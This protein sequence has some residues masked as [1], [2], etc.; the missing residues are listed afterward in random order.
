MEVKSVLSKNSTV[1]IQDALDSTKFW[2]FDAVDSIF[3]LSAFFSVPESGF[4]EY[5]LD[6]EINADDLD[7][8]V[9]MLIS[10]LL[11]NHSKSKK[12]DGEEE[13][14]AGKK[15]EKEKDKKEGEKTD[16]EES[17]EKGEKTDKKESRESVIDK[18]RKAAEDTV[19]EMYDVES[20]FAADITINDVDGKQWKIP[21]TEN[22]QRIFEKLAE[23]CGE[24]GIEEIQPEHMLAACFEVNDEV[25]ESFFEELAISFSAAKRHFTNKAI[26][27]NGII[28]YMYASFLVN[29]NTDVDATK[30]CPI[31]M[32]D[33]E[34]KQLWNI[35]HKFNKRNAV[36]V[37]EA[38]VGKTALIELMAYQ[39]VTE[40]CPEKFK[41]FNM[42]KLD[43]NSLI[44]GTKYRGDAEER[45]EGLIEFLEERNNVI[46]FIDEVHTIL[47]AGS[48]FEGEM[49]L[50]NA[51]KPILARGDTIVIGATTK[52]EYEKYFAKDAALARRF[53]VITVDEPLAEDVYPMIKNKIEI[54]SSFHGVKI[55]RE[56]VKYAILIASCFENNKKNPDRTLDLIDRSMV[57]AY[58]AGK[59]KVDKACVLENFDAFFDLFK[60]MTL[61]S[62]KEIAYHEIGHLLVILDSETLV[63]HHFLAISIMPT[64]EYFGVTVCENEKKKMPFYNLEYFKDLLAL[65]LA[66]RISEREFHGDYTSGAW[67]DL[68]AA[69]ELALDV[70]TRYGMSVD[71]HDN[72]K[73][74]DV[75]INSPEY[76]MF[77]EIAKEK[78]NSEA[79]ALLAEGYS[80]AEAIIKEHK[81]FVEML[82]NELVE[83]KIM[84]AIEVE[85]LWNEYKASKASAQ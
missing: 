15:Q 3:L 67:G 4:E 39:I 12:D 50:A 59:K 1:V 69:K 80:R 77:S 24:K 43:V 41:G 23:I 54:L 8:L 21:V 75:I 82:V 13:K 42:I 56:M 16:K 72:V 83:K 14:E 33:K 52:A 29:M 48:C 53:E 45:I 51:L 35:C 46:L 62:K 76:P 28:P 5:F 9:H 61:K 2:N 40:T 57:S 71:Q 19:K 84:S 10:D 20:I 27:T 37:G 6:K 78:S 49:D 70:V 55:S 7:A 60:G 17:K 47:G 85:K 25:F 30:P 38:G 66:G 58:M 32:R 18:I 44:A 31:L 65:K 74:Y 81:D 36:I 63:D 64:R 68:A 22:V 73:K 26:Y 34:V 11:N 79:I